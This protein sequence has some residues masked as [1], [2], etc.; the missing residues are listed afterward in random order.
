MFR[1]CTSLTTA[2]AELPAMTMASQCY[3]GMFLNCTKLTTAPKLPA[4]TLGYAC[5]YCMFQGCTSLTTAYVKAAYTDF[6]GQCSYMFS[7]CTAT[8][9]K[10]H[11]TTA[12]QGSWT[13][14]MG[15]ANWTAVGDWND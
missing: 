7:S 14:H 15:G 12:N 10:L 9:A 11:T 13:G 6:S 2:P 1:G 4:T 5:Y 3:A 8:G